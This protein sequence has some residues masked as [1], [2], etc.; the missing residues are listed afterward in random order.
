VALGGQ[1]VKPA[2]R[3]HPRLFV[4]VFG[5][6]PGAHVVGVEGR[7][8]GN[9]L[10]HPHLDIAAQL[11]VGAATGHVGGNRHRA[12]LAGV[13]HDLG[14]LF[15]LAGVQNIVGDVFGFQHFRQGFG[16]LDAGGADQ[17]RLPQGMG[18]LDRLDH[19]GVFLGGA[20][21]NL[22]VFILARDRLVG[23]HFDHPSL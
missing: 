4:G 22:V 15:M 18:L 14:F 5:L 12:E 19:T 7:V 16:F 6:D 20:A 23:R 10:Q 9:R 1:H 3:N 2:R 8:G 13:G 17:H 11:D 21:V